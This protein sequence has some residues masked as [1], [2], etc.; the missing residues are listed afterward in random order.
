MTRGRQRINT[1][2][3][4]EPVSQLTPWG[5]EGMGGGGVGRP[6]ARAGPPPE[7]LSEGG[8]LR[9][10]ARRPGRGEGLQLASSPCLLNVARPSTSRV[11]R[12]ESREG[13]RPRP[14][15]RRREPLLSLPLAWGGAGPLQTGYLSSLRTFSPLVLQAFLSC[16][17]CAVGRSVRDSCAGSGPCP[18]EGGRSWDGRDGRGGG[19]QATKEKACGCSLTTQACVGQQGVTPACR[20]PAYTCCGLG[21][22]RASGRPGAGRPRSEGVLVG[23]GLGQ[24]G[25]SL[26]VG[27]VLSHLVNHTR[28]S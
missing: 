8:G 27:A 20:A 5:G 28:S 16:L 2:A 9:G 3:L 4:W 11:C 25:G 13:E 23:P 10:E 19:A 15:G 24:A 17:L 22:G 7:G 1:E 12:R 6:G 21:V 26:T 14:C 18:L